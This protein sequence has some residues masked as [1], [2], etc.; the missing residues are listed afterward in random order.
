MTTYKVASLKSSLTKIRAAIERRPNVPI[1]S[2][3]YIGSGLVVGT[4]LD[5]KITVDMPSATGEPVCIPFD[6]L[7]RI[8]TGLPSDGL[9][10]ISELGGRAIIDFDD[11][12][13]S[14]MTMTADYYPLDI[15]Q[16]PT[17]VSMPL[18]LS[19]MAALVPFVCREK[20]RHYLN[21]IS[22]RGGLLTA[23]DGHRI[24]QVPMPGADQDAILPIEAINAM[25]KA[26]G[27]KSTINI[28]MNKGWFFAANEEGVTVSGKMIDGA[29]PDASRIMPKPEDA[30]AVYTV[31]GSDLARKMT[32]ICGMQGHSSVQIVGNANG[33]VEVRRANDGG[34]MSLAL[35]GKASGPFD[36]NFN[37]EY[38]RQIAAFHGEG[39]MKMHIGKDRFHP[40]L[41]TSSDRTSVLMPMLGNRKDMIVLPEGICA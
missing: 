29:F 16:A 38:L 1:L 17:G 31:N 11:G 23:T 22:F 28:G 12:R 27:V 30:T 39:D 10:G 25:I 36:V 40:L 20:T 4:N 32:R 8:V 9:V 3:A 15:I 35:H 41:V 19:S 33:R 13:A 26:F 37:P 34:A 24:G 21:G 14:L 2:C 7:M 18:Q 5:I 6:P